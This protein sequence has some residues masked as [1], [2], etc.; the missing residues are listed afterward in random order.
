MESFE[1]NKITAI[2]A[3]LVL[4][5][6]ISFAANASSNNTADIS[7][8]SPASMSGGNVAEM[9]GDVF[10]ARGSSAAHKAVKNETFSSGTAISTGAQSFAVLKF[11]DGQVVTMQ[12]NSTFLVREYRYEPN[13]MENNHIVFSM[14]KGGLR[15]LT[16]LIGQNNR[17]A[18]RLST[19][20][21]TIGIRGTE[22]MVAMA[23]N[24]MYSQ[25]LVGNIGMTNSAGTVA[26]GAGQTA[27]IASAS[28]LAALI[29]ASAIPPG[30]FSQLLSITA[31]T[32]P[33][34]RPT[35]PVPAA[36]IA[37]PT[38]SAAPVSPVTAPANISADRKSV[39]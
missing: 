2:L 4:L 13:H 27:Y 35:S 30:T 11:K 36:S 33:E 23:N 19:P 18:F 25:V 37:S 5:P 16:G 38:P 29:P 10:I 6:A 26:L 21:A 14:I 31:S 3:A 7:T 22:F 15:F 17:Q 24:S 28:A 34:M 12:A 39:V 9:S 32:A 20:N 1:M 8:T